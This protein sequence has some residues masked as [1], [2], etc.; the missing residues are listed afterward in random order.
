MSAFQ[1]AALCAA[2]AV[3]LGPMVGVPLRQLARD[4]APAGLCSLALVAVGWPLARALAG[5]LPAFPFVAVVS[6][7]CAAVYLV[8]LRTLFPAAW[9]DLELLVRSLLRRPPPDA[10]RAPRVPAAPAPSR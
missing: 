9:S 10:A 5:T 4:V 3:M 8:A 7:A 2:Y 1:V 6:L